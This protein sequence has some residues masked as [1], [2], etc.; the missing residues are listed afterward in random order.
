M[1]HDVA[2]DTNPSNRNDSY[3]MQ[4]LIDY[5]ICNVTDFQLSGCPLVVYQ[6]RLYIH[7]I[8]CPFVCLVV[9]F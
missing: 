5:R 1:L 3:K 4:L 2:N 7:M 6:I 8:V 9:S